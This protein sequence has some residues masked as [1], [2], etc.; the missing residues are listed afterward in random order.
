M[1]KSH[2]APRKPLTLLDM[3]HPLPPSSSLRVGLISI[4]PRSDSVQSQISLSSKDAVDVN[5]CAR[6]LF[7]TLR[8]M[9]SDDNIDIIYAERC[10]EWGLG[11]AVNDRLQRASYK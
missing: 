9:D 2:Y 8:L 10:P 4:L 6:N 5:E 3:G 7:K 11:R 1:L